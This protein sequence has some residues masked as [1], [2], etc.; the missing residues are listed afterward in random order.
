[1]LSPDMFRDNRVLASGG[2]FEV[3]HERQLIALIDD[4]QTIGVHIVRQNGH[5]SMY[6]RAVRHGDALLII[7]DLRDVDAE[8]KEICSTHPDDVRGLIYYTLRQHY[9][10]SPALL[11]AMLAFPKD[12][13]TI[14]QPEGIAA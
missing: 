6:L 14:R 11:S 5:D 1:M 9:K 13:L 7:F 8:L 2:G 4:K 12:V 10:T 3:L